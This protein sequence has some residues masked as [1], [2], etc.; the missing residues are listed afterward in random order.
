VILACPTL[1]PAKEV[2]L[3]GRCTDALTAAQAAAIDAI[4]V[5]LKDHLLKILAGSLE[6]LNA[7]NALPERTAAAQTP[8]PAHLQ[9]QGDAAKAPL[10]M[11]N[12]P[13]AP[14]LTSQTR[15]PAVRA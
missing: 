7:R 15:S 4:E 1:Q 12:R 3:H 6:G 9:L 5:L 14:T 2:A 13:V 8:A 11:P 10:I